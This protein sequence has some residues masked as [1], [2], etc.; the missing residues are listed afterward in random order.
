[1]AP[2]LLIS[3]PASGTGKTTLT[4]ALAR[5]FRDRGLV[6]QCFKS[7]PDYIDPAFHAAATGRLSANL[8]SWSMDRV[9][10]SALATRGA[11]ADLILAEGS[12]GLFDGVAVPGAMGT[13][14]S[15][16]IAEMMDWP[17]LLVLDPAGQAQTAAAVA[18]GLAA[19]RPGVRIAGVVLNRVASPRHEALV[20]AGMD[21]VAIRVFGALPRHVPITLPERH[22]GLVQAEEIARLSDLIGEAARLVAE[23]V[24]LDALLAAAGCGKAEVLRKPYATRPPGQRI[25]LARDA[26]FSFVYPHLIEGWRAAGAE[27][28]AFSPLAD[29]G[30]DDNA[31]VCWLPGGYPELHAPRLSAASNFRNKLRAFAETRPVHGECGGYMVMGAGLI[32]AD[33]TRH[34]MAGLL[35]L[36]TSFAKRKMHLGYRLAEFDAPLLQHNRGARIRGHEYHYAT[37]VAQPDAPLATVSDATGARVAET[38]SRKGQA[39]GTFFHM[40]AEAP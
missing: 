11:D 36:E 31:D 23:R 35:G 33:G 28:I 17:V 6:V 22:L 26:A 16:D 13:G 21:A 38:G 5:A 14:A 24:D 3:A 29:E 15:A 39:T 40:I 12:M 9:M 37:I 7:G 1:M 2:G 19:F 32:A 8:D 20:R 30:P 27:I 34:E 4:L 25:A 10:I 18:A